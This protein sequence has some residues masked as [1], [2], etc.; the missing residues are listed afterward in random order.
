MDIGYGNTSLS[1]SSA[2]LLDVSTTSA[3]D[4]TILIIKVTYTGQTGSS[5]ECQDL[6]DALIW[7]SSN[8]DVFPAGASDIRTDTLV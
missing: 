7:D 3:D 1:E 8:E 2:M 6:L 5:V 4:T